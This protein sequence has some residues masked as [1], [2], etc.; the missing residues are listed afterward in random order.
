MIEKHSE[1]K[2]SLVFVSSRKACQQA[3][4]QIRKQYVEALAGT[5]P[6]PWPKPTEKLRAED[7]G[8]GTLLPY[9]IGIHHAGMSSQDKFTVE[10]NFH[11]ATLSVVVCTTTLAVGVNL[12]ARVVIVRGTV[13]WVNGRAQPYS[14]LDLLQVSNS[15]CVSAAWVRLTEAESFL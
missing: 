13:G 12:P 9:G 1:G 14:D 6:P 2:P 15:S 10:R 11:D 8:L 7:K 5:Q 4:D 3:A